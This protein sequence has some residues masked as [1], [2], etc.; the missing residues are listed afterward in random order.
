MQKPTHAT[1]LVGSQKGPNSTSNS[2]GTFL[3]DKLKQ[4]GVTTERVFISQC[5]G[6]DEKIASMLRTVDNSD[7]VIIAFP[8]YGDGLPSLAIKTLELISEHGV[9]DENK[10]FAA[11]ANC[12]FPEGMHNDTALAVCRIFARQAGF[13]WAGGLGMGG[14]PTVSRGSLTTIGWSNLLIRN[15]KKALGIA[16][17]ALS[18][19]EPIPK[20][21]TA[22]MAKLGYPVSFYL[23]FANRGWRSMIKKANSID[24]LYDQPFK[25]VV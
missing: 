25:V 19:G 7:L 14:G 21:A 1:L 4:K 17:D 18:K 16:A 24:K 22:L 3:L 5:L 2:I 11:I 9:R 20:K 23:W 8:L 15:Q 13:K 6:S 10:S 12:G